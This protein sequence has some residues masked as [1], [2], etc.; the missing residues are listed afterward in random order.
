MY[1][2]GMSNELN[3]TTGRYLTKAATDAFTYYIG[4][5]DGSIYV[6]YADNTVPPRKERGRPVIDLTHIKWG[7]ISDIEE[8]KAIAQQH[9]NQNA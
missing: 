8:A 5:E 6:S 4:E 2:D 3:W 7:G 9:A 1:S